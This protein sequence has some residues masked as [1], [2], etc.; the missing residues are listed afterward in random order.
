LGDTFR[1]CRS[2]KIKTEMKLNFQGEIEKL[3][4]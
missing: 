2:L 4:C 1:N 3:F